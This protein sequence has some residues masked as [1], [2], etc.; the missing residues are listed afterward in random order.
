MYFSLQAFQEGGGGLRLP[1]GF[2]AYPLSGRRNWVRHGHSPH[3]QGEPLHFQRQVKKNVSLLQIREEY[4]DRI[5]NTYSVVPS[6]KVSDTV[7]EPYNATLSVHQVLPVLPET[8]IYFFI[9]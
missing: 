1:A 5:M 7:V 6:P 9:L 2:P 8:P 3:L 4:P